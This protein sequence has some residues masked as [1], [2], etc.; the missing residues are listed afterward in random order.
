LYFI[1]FAEV[2]WI[3]VFLGLAHARPRVPAGDHLTQQEFYEGWVNKI[4]VFDKAVKEY[5]KENGYSK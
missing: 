4:H 1:S 3:N 2:Y 5:L